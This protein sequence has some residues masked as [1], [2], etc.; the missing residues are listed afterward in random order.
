MRRSS[1]VPKVL[2]LEFTIPRLL[3]ARYNIR[4]TIVAVPV[5]QMEEAALA[6]PPISLREFLSH[7][8]EKTRVSHQVLKSTTRLLY[9]CDNPLRAISPLPVFLFTVSR[10]GFFISKTKMLFFSSSQYASIVISKFKKKH[11]NWKSYIVFLSILRMKRILFILNLL[12]L[13]NFL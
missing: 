11:E 9:F 5:M 1:L 8:S 3:S 13:K 6:N 7:V 12:I 4:K 2:S 10:T